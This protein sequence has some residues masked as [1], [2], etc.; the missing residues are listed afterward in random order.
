MKAA[1]AAARVESAVRAQSTVAAATG[2]PPS[3]PSVSYSSVHWR[4]ISANSPDGVGSGSAARN[5]A[6]RFPAYRLT[7]PTASLTSCS[8]PSGK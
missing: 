6:T 4:T 7:Q 8:L 1:S 5:R 3:N 2:Q